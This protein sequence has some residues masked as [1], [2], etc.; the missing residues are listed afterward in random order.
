MVRRSLFEAKYAPAVELQNVKRMSRTRQLTPTS[1]VLDSALVSQEYDS[2]LEDR[3]VDLHGRV[4]R[5]AYRALPSRRVYM[6]SD[7]TPP[8]VA[9]K[10]EG[11][12]L[13]GWTQIVGL[14]VY[15]TA[16]GQREPTQFRKLVS[17]KR[18][19]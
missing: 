5:G 4:H 18:L 6:L 17:R 9:G 2:G 15:D 11:W 12:T 7:S 3:L 10:S 1:Q 13:C 14:Y 8:I 19:A 16:V